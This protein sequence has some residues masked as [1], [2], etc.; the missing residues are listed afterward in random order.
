MNEKFVI[1]QIRIVEKL[2]ASSKRCQVRQVT[3]AKLDA[4]LLILRSF[5]DA[6]NR[7]DK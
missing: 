7:R 5:L 4:A 6:A 1:A 3:D 2:V